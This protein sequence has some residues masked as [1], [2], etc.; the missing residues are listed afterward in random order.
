MM[1]DFGCGLHRDKA[2]QI[3]YIS[4]LLEQLEIDH[5]EL[6]YYWERFLEGKNQV[7]EMDEIIKRISWLK[8]GIFFL[9]YFMHNEI[10]GISFYKVVEIEKDL[11]FKEEYLCRIGMNRFLR[12][13][14]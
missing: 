7:V 5:S 14:I 4:S 3:R 10:E 2:S 1:M 9:G 8:Q 11:T 12:K 6:T 13:E